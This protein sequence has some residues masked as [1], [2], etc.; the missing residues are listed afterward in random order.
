MEMT[1]GFIEQGAACHPT[2]H[3]LHTPV[4]I[5]QKNLEIFLPIRGICCNFAGYRP[6][7]QNT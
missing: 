6:F 4:E 1:C 5:V 2:M 3:P 7:I